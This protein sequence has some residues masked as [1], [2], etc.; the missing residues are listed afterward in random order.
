MQ[1][2]EVWTTGRII[3]TSTH[4][5]PKF[6]LWFGLVAW[7]MIHQPCGGGVDAASAQ[8]PVTT[9]LVPFSNANPYADAF[10][11]AERSFLVGGNTIKVSCIW[12]SP[13]TLHP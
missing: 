3:L 13:V 1:R 7:A 4:L 9:A 6:W 10:K 2:G 12:L 8:A 5:F 11:L